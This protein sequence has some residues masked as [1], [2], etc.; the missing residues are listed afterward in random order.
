MEARAKSYKNLGDNAF[1]RRKYAE[2]AAMYNKAV[3]VHPQPVYMSSLA[4]TYLELEDYEKAEDAASMALIHDPRMTR[5]RFLRGLARK[6]RHQYLAA[7]IDFEM[8]LREDPICAEAEEELG[9]MQRL[10]K[11]FGLSV[12][13]SDSAQYPS[14]SP[15]W[16]AQ[17]PMV[18]E[19]VKPHSHASGLRRLPDSI[20]DFHNLP[21]I[22]R[23]TENIRQ[24][25]L[26]YLKE[27]HVAMR[28][29]WPKLKRAAQEERARK[30]ERIAETRRNMELFAMIDMLPED[31]PVPSL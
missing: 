3:D 5:A 22:P 20:V 14:P 15:D 2:A 7:K 17:P 16:P 18:I 28:A 30:A 8:V 4:A 26:N 21:D 13:D 11:M 23:S 19:V 31:G 29:A 1:R 6:G 12:D 25:N 10:C 27:T 9:G 24:R